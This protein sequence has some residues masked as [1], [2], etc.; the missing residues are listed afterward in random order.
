MY[1]RIAV[2][3]ILK[4]S[5]PNAK[6]MD[7]VLSSRR[8]VG[9]FW[10]WLCRDAETF[11]KQRLAPRGSFEARGF[12][13]QWWV[14]PL[15]GRWSNHIQ[16]IIPQFCW[17]KWCLPVYH[18]LGGGFTSMK[19]G[20]WQPC[21]FYVPPWVGKMILKWGFQT[22]KRLCPNNCL[23]PKRIQTA[24]EWWNMLKSWRLQPS[25]GFW[26]IHGYPIFVPLSLVLV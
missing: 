22:I 17:M 14:R 18:F 21:E 25:I 7:I 16:P 19:T 9:P 11:R 2:L 6:N 23:Y 24:V 26:G 5:H 20:S 3:H 1:C 15:L 8:T 4:T 12:K 10:K 13:C